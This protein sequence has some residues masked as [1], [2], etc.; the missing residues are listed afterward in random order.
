MLRVGWAA[1]AHSR[2]GR[3]SPGDDSAVD[4]DSDGEVAAQHCASKGLDGGGEEGM[5]CEGWHPPLVSQTLVLVANSKSS[6]AEAVG[7]IKTGRETMG[8]LLLAWA[9]GILLQAKRSSLLTTPAT[10]SPRFLSR[11]NPSHCL[12]LAALAD[13]NQHERLRHQG[14]A[15]PFSLL[16]SIAAE[17]RGPGK[18]E[19]ATGC[20]LLTAPGSIARAA[21]R[22]LPLPA[23]LRHAK[24]RPARG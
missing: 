6:E 13:S 3:H 16:P 4:A 9:T 18:H 23:W 10:R 20:G 15:P 14:R 19:D 22:L 7:C 1:R 21:P 17:D 5:E 11:L 12:F 2:T 8:F 24:A